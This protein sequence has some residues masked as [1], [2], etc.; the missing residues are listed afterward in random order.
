MSDY[1]AYGKYE[2]QCFCA[3]Y[4]CAKDL[5]Y[6]WVLCRGA[7]TE[8]FRKQFRRGFAPIESPSV[9]PPAIALGLVSRLVRLGAL[10]TLRHHLGTEPTG[11][12]SLQVERAKISFDI[13]SRLITKNIYKV[14]TFVDTRVYASRANSVNTKKSKIFRLLVAQVLS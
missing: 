1:T 4:R 11:A 10:H 3:H 8:A 9:R 12:L 13:I 5:G 2:S 6:W 7:K 14:G